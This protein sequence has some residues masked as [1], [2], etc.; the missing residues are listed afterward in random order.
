[1]KRLKRLKAEGEEVGTSVRKCTNN[2]I[3]V[4]AGRDVGTGC[5]DTRKKVNNFKESDVPAERA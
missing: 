1:M 4:D 3:P 2:S 5:R